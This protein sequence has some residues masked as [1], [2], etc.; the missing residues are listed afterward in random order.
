MNPVIKKIAVF[1]LATAVLV[2][3][4]FAIT[5]HNGRLCNSVE[6]EIDYQDGEPI[7]TKEDVLAYLKDYN[8]KMQ[9]ERFEAIDM[10]SLKSVLSKH[11]YIHEF[12]GVSNI[13]NKLFIQLVQVKP[14]MHVFTENEEQYFID[15]SGDYLPYSPKIRVKTIIVNGNIREKF[16]AGKSLAVDTAKT[17]IEHAYVM[18]KHFN[19][20]DFLKAQFEQIYITKDKEI[21]LIPVYGSHVVLLSDSKDIEKKMTELVEMYKQ[22][23]NREGWEKYKILN[24]KYKDRIIGVKSDK[25]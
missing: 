14:L 15:Q 19:T 21:E 8:I 24:L 25:I 6:V 3:V 5:R 11:P 13:G 16:S 10:D 18:V 23:L 2:G 7:L 12:N 9:G 20:N 17:P 22:G 1:V 4:I